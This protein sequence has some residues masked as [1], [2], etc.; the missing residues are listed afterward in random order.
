M[1]VKF[2]E[3]DVAESSCPQPSETPESSKSV[4]IPL[5]SLTETLPVAL[6][7]EE[8]VTL[9]VQDEDLGIL[10]TEVPQVHELAPY[11]P[12]VHEPSPEIPQVHE[13]APEIPLR[14]SQRERKPAIGSDYQVYLGIKSIVFG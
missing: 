12:Q 2:H 4:S 5:P 9:L 8:M 7:R 13:P 14:R 10:V 1:N 3:L 11:I 6:A